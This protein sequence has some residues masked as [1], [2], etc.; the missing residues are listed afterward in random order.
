[1][2][3]RV[4]TF[5]Y[6]PLAQPVDPEAMADYYDVVA[7]P[8]DLADLR[9]RAH[10]GAYGDGTGLGLQSFIADVRAI[11]DNSSC[12]NLPVCVCD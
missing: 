4:C 3:Q 10:D 1:M 8:A 5:L 6:P 9:R 2:Q 11:L 12:Y 7:R